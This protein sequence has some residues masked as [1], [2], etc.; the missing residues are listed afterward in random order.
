MESKK[1][2]IFFHYIKKMVKLCFL[3]FMIL[4]FSGCT[5]NTDTGDNRPNAVSPSPPE[6][7][8][9][10]PDITSEPDTPAA[11]PSPIPTALPSDF[12][13][14]AAMELVA[15][16]IISGSYDISL[17][18][19]TLVLDSEKYYT[20]LVSL[21]GT[22]IEPL[23]IVNQQTGELK[24]ISSDNT[25]S[26]ITI[27]PLYQEPD[28]EIITWEGTYII[29]SADGILS[30][31]II[32]TPLDTRRFEFTAY[33]Y[34]ET[35]ISELS[36]IAEIKEDTASF[37]SEGGI[38]LTFSWSGSSLIIKQQPVSSERNFSGTYT[39]TSEADSTVTQISM[40]EA[41]QKLL[42][43]TAEE[44]M[45]KRPMEEYSYYVQDEAVILNDHLCY[46]IIAYT[47]KNNRLFYVA[48]FYITV[49]GVSIYRLADNTSE[50]IEIYSIR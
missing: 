5:K 34:L 25:V 21:K 18:S 35:G 23:I 1:Y 4:T 28:A 42:T 16:T 43:L 39:Y 30:N 37:S 33:V 22:A 9:I 49:D 41:L 44:S 8:D 29:Q 50:D 24:C 17:V 6:L 7:T 47:E 46:S 31:Y 2:H 10:P 38:T 36:G 32:L 45:L 40:E 19:N 27:H 48:Q 3:C 11:S 20:F 15:R 13:P 26:E 12:S 14:E